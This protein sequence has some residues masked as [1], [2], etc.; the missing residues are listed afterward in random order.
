MA[1]WRLLPQDAL[2]RA[3][4]VAAVQR[5]SSDELEQRLAQGHW[6]HGEPDGFLAFDTAV[7]LR[8]SWAVAGSGLGARCEALRARMAAHPALA[9]AL[10]TE[11]ISLDSLQR[12]SL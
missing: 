2:A 11:G 8:W 4:D 5:P 12:L 10:A 6:G 9:R 1:G 7:F 3:R